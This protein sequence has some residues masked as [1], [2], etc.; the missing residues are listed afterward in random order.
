MIY[1]NLEDLELPQDWLDKADELTVKL[2]SLTSAD[3]TDFIK[4][5]R[6]LT[7]GDR[8]LVEALSRV[9][10][11]KCWYSEVSLEGQDPNVDHFRP[12]GRV[13]DV[14]IDPPFE[15][16]GKTMDGGYWWL[17]FQ[18][19]NFRLSSMHANQRRVDD[20]TVGGKADFFPVIGNRATENTLLEV[21]DEDVLPLDPCVLSDMEL[22]WFE[23]DGKL[24]FKGWKR[25]PTIE[26]ERRLQ[27]STW[28]YHLDKNH[29]VKARNASVNDVRSDITTADAYYKMWNPKGPNINLAYRTQFNSVVAKIKSKISNKSP[30][31]GAKRCAVRLAS[32]KYS[33][34]TD[35]VLM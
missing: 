23:P 11:H 10:G 13:L 8:R 26:E 14:S 20:T 29:I 34:I 31:A 12:K 3:R 5:N 19:K 21:I 7:W 27:T 35:F 25:K 2:L 17:A 24:G 16:T 32:A 18:W 15:K 9:T 30:F 28:L 6:H 22:I 4:K 33:W 1:I